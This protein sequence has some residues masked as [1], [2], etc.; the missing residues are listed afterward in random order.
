M[1]NYF[2]LRGF[3]IIP[4]LEKGLSLVQRDEAQQIDARAR[5]C[6]IIGNYFFHKKTINRPIIG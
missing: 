6:Q 5:A 2:E 4:W 3:N 1:A